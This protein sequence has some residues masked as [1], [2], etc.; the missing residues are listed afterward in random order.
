MQ[1]LMA[2][3][4]DSKA[5]ADKRGWY[6]VLGVYGGSEPR[7]MQCF[8]FLRERYADTPSFKMKHYGLAKLLKDF[9]GDWDGLLDYIWIFGWYFLCSMERHSSEYISGWPAERN[10]HQCESL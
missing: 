3:F 1:E 10:V 5:R 8:E 4:G 2:D 7:A 9:E 6:K